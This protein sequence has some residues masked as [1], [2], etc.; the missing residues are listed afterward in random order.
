[1]PSVGIP[2]V[3]TSGSVRGAPG[4]ETLRGP[5]DRMIPTGCRRAM[6]AA[7]QLRVLRAE[8]Q[9]DDRLMGHRRPV[10]T[11]T[12]GRCLAECRYYKRVTRLA[13][14]ICW[15]VIALMGDGLLLAAGQG[16]ARRPSPRRPVSA[17]QPAVQP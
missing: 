4:S 13:A 7:D 15:G 8:I 16:Q 9:N 17:K 11:Q 1:M 5:P 12:R 14:T 6:S 10:G 3:R 2:S